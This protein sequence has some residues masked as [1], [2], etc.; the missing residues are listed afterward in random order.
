[1]SEFTESM[2]ETLIP[3]GVKDFLP[4]KA[5][6]IAFLEQTLGGVFA[7]WGF[8][9]VIPPSL[10]NLDVLEKGLGSG[11]REKTFRF[12]DRQGGR[13]VAF[14]PDITPQIARIVATRMQ[15]LPLP[16]RLCYSGRVLRHAEQQAG[17]DR[18]I[19]QAGV[20]LIGLDSP[21]AD[22]EMIAMAVE[23]LSVL[24]AKDFTIDI[25]QVEFFR[26]VMADLQLPGD[27]LRRLQEAIGR[28]DSSGLGKLLDGLTIPA[29]AR[30]AISSLPRLFGGRE[31]LPRA[32]QAVRNERSRHALANLEQVL[33][34]LEVYGVERHITIDLG[35]TRGLDYHTG[36]TFQGFLPG[37]GRAVCSGGRYDNLTS[38]YGRRAP[39]T[40]FTFNLLN[41]LFALDRELDRQV[42][43]RTDALLFQLGE[44]KRPAQLVA[45]ALRGKGYSAARDMY[46]RSL[47]ESLDYAERMDFRFVMV[48]GAADQPI[49]LIRSGD[50]HEESTS[51]DAIQADG[52]VL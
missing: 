48:I 51:L 45:R 38:R 3:K 22:A 14:P 31:I 35:E 10:E 23:A 30:E 43:R 27:T 52:F 1:M 17:K 6:K 20:E 24:G 36:I 21:E 15:D 33:D 39:A 44:D 47:A 46:P 32:A 42:S 18:E 19:F 41:L 12:D 29:E 50:R 28:K 7:R 16:L 13:L 2:I 26:G 34:I 8:R 5:A 9:P 4:I 49:R 25:G 11:L 40:G 37:L